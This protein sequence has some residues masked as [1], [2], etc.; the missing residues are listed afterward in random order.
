[1][2]LCCPGALGWKA[3]GWIS[4][5]SEAK[6]NKKFPDPLEFFFKIGAGGFNQKK[7]EEFLSSNSPVI[8]LPKVMRFQCSTV[9]CD[10]FRT[11]GNK[12]PEII[13]GRFSDV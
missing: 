9:K 11:Q 8:A 12:T 3:L 2:S 7:R 6:K 13:S 1:M 10:L 4:V 5:P